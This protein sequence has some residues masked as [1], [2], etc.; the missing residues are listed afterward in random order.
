MIV[1]SRER[2]ILQIYH[3]PV[4]D[5]YYRAQTGN[6]HI[7]CAVNHPPGSCCHYGEQQLEWIQINEALKALGPPREFDPPHGE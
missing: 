1:P 5:K 4:C 2:T 3:C 6:V 7:S